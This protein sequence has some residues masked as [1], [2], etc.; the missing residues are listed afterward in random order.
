MNTSL[1]LAQALADRYAVER[2]LGAGGMATVREYSTRECTS[3][4]LSA[5]LRECGECEGDEEQSATRTARHTSLQGEVALALMHGAAS[6]GR[7]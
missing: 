7:Q 2:E 5:C 3:H 4:C 1:A 6:F